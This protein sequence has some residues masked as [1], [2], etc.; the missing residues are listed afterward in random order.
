MTKTE[1]EPGELARSLFSLEGKVAL[2][3]GAGRGLGLQIARALASAGATIVLGGREETRL[4]QAV[5]LIADEGARAEA[6]PFDQQDA[7]ET[8]AAFDRIVQRH[9]RLDILVANAGARS[10]TGFAGLD[11]AS[12]A[13]LLETNLIGTTDL[14]QRAGKLMSAAGRG[15]RIIIMGSVVSSLASAADPGYL[16]SK[17]GLSGMMRA[18]A[19]EF[20]PHGITVNEIAPGS[21][22]TEFNAASVANEEA[23]ARIRARTLLGRWGQPEE[24]AGA[25]LFLASPGA[26]YVTGHRL[27]VDGGM[28]VKA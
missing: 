27:V 12:F 16:A 26:A 6:C 21:F 25:V 14:A 22:A 7:E 8:A 24:I 4:A 1:P 20:G 19:A 9:G 18:L 15:G 23:N 28:S 5:R 10:R 11:R 17:A 2:V 3:T 13:R